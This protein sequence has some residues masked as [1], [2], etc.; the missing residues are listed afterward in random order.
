[1]SP[2]SG[3][4]D[5]ADLIDHVL[6]SGHWRLAYATSR[7]SYLPELSVDQGGLQPD[8]LQLKPQDEAAF[9]AEIEV[10]RRRL[11][12]IAWKQ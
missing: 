9:A 10:V 3:S 7:L 1:M 12:N 8:I 2:G 6:P 5:Y 11:E 4:L